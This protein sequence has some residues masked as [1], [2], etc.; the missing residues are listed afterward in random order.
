MTTRTRAPA[1]A[2]LITA[3]MALSACIPT[4]TQTT[5]QPPPDSDQDAWGDFF[6]GVWD[7]VETVD[8]LSNE[9]QQRGM[10]VTRG[11]T[12]NQPFLEASGT[13]LTV[14]GET[15]QVFEYASAETAR[16]D[17]AQISDDGG[18]IGNTPVTWDGDPHFYREGRLLVLY[19]GNNPQLLN[20]LEDILGNQIAGA[21]R[22]D[23]T[24][25]P[26]PDTGAG[27]V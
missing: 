16:R 12:F 3:L 10:T 2:L 5:G 9:L 1:A 15:I 11:Q 27:G 26:M 19:V 18:T 21:P 24:A 8:E 14:N 20:A 13:E 17:A 4:D 23:G 25:E 7:E 6:G 22:T